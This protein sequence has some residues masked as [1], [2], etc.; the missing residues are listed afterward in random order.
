LAAVALERHD[1]KQALALHKQLLELDEAPVELLYNTGLLLQKLGR[2][3]EAAGYYQKAL[4]QRPGFPQA[5][6]NL[7]HALMSL[8]R[9]EEAHTCWQAALRSDMDLTENFLV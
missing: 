5:L 8:G 4:D 1:F 6:L 7:G 2:A 3:K 9:Q